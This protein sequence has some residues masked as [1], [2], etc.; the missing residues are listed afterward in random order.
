MEPRT[1]VRKITNQPNKP[2]TLEAGS[3]QG[4]LFSSA[5]HLRGSV[6]RSGCMY[7]NFQARCT[8]YDP[9]RQHITKPAELANLSY[10]AVVHESAHRLLFRCCSCLGSLSR[11]RSSLACHPASRSCSH[12]RQYPA[13]GCTTRYRETG[14]LFWVRSREVSASRLKDQETIFEIARSEHKARQV[15]RY[16]HVQT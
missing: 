10:G 16:T 3:N 5:P 11:R 13:E 12:S 8:G 1:A 4:R 6:S 2:C 9:S 14:S 7:S 15:G